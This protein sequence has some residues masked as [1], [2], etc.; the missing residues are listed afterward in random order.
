VDLTTLPFVIKEEIFKKWQPEF[1]QASNIQQ[2]VINASKNRENIEFFLATYSGDEGEL[3]SSV[4]K[5]Y[6]A[7]RW[8]LINSIKVS[9]N[10]GKE[11]QLIKVVSPSGQYRYILY[12]YQFSGEVFTSKIKLKLYQTLMTMLGQTQSSA[13]IALSME[14]D[15]EMEVVISMIKSKVKLI[16]DSIKD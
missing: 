1:S 10:E 5:L 14:S 12:W 16:Q 6:G 13:I 8:T 4:N 2:G 15:K 11:V 7:D 9:I 3:I